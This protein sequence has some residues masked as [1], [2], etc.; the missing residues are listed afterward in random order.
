MKKENGGQEPP[1]FFFFFFFFWFLFP[2]CASAFASPLSFLPDS[3]GSHEPHDKAPIVCFNGAS[4]GCYCNPR[5]IFLVFWSDMIHVSWDGTC[6]GN[7]VKPPVAVQPSRS[8]RRSL[9][10]S[11]LPVPSLPSPPKSGA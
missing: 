6:T 5:Q 10:F 11:S 3:Y 1:L 8:F 7:D 2:L 9:S 4:K